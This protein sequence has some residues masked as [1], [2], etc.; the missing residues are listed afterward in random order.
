MVGTATGIGA[1]LTTVATGTTGTVGT[2]IAIGA[3]FTTVATG[4]AETIG[5]GAGTGATD[6]IPLSLPPLFPSE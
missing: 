2:A 1:A 3:A 6:A 5:A 4:T